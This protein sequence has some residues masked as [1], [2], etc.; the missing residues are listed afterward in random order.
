MGAL[1]V[2]RGPTVAHRHHRRLGVDGDGLRELATWW[3]Q[4]PVTCGRKWWAE[5]DDRSCS[6]R[7]RHDGVAHGR[8][9]QWR[10][11]GNGETRQRTSSVTAPA[12]GSGVMRDAGQWLAAERERRGEAEAEALRQGRSDRAMLRQRRFIIVRAR[13][14]GGQA[15][16]DVVCGTRWSQS[17]DSRTLTR[18]RGGRYVGPSYRHFSD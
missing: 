11:R 12:T 6:S 15:G 17:P 8:V 9:A 13:E 10:R 2:R 18:D 1:A 5:W 7:R 16:S 3:L 4:A 14:R